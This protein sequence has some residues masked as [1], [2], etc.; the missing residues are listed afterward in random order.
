MRG[1]RENEVIERRRDRARRAADR[2]DPGSAV[3]G[4]APK[5]R[6]RPVGGG[7]QRDRHRLGLARVRIG[8]AEL[9]ERL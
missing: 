3:I 2:I 9:R 1:R 8:Q 7:R 6:E 4:A 5:V